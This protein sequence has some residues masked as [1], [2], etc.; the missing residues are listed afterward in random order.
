MAAK[1]TSGKR[2][3]YL[4][5]QPFRK[6]DRH[7]FFGR[8]EDIE[9]LHDFILLE[10]IVVLFGKSGYG[11]SSLLS[12]GVLPRLTDEAQPAAY[13]FRTVEARF[14]NYVEGSSFAPLETLR[15]ILE[16]EM[17][18]A[19]SAGSDLTNFQ[20]LSNLSPSNLSPSLWQLFKQ[21]QFSETPVGGRQSAVGGGNP[22]PVGSG[23]SAVGGGNPEPVGGGQS[24]EQPEIRNQES[25]IRNQESGI[26]NQE[27]E[28]R[29]QESAS[30]FLLVFDQFEEFFSYPAEQQEA[31]RRQLAELLY[32]DVPQQV[33]ENL[34]ALSPEARSRMATP[35]NVKAVFSI[36]SD[37][38]SHL[39]SMKD[40][41]PTILHKRY[42]LRP[43]TRSQAE[44]AIVMPARLGHDDAGSW[45]EQYATP[46]F[47]YERPALD[48]MLGS[49]ALESGGASAAGVEA[50]LLQILCDKVESLVREGKLPDLDGNGLPDVTAD[51]LPDMANL[52]EDYTHRKL[53]ELDPA[54]RPAARRLLEDGLL[55]E[56]ALSGEGRRTS[57]DG[58][59]LLAQFRQHGLSQALLDDLE[60]TYL[61]R[62]EPNT[63]GGFSYEI[64]HDRLVA[65]VQKM[66]KE[67]LVKEEKERLAKRQRQLVGIIALV[68]LV[69]GGAIALA[70]WA[71]GQKNEAVKAKVEAQQA[72]IQSYNSDIA[73][74]RQEIGVAERNLSTFEQY[75]A[76]PDVK[77]L[78][79]N[80]IDSLKELINTLDSKIKSLEK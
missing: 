8:D 9:N 79:S 6:G 4:G 14:G 69:A 80:R 72:L 65:P 59:A 1:P 33:R 78:E 20:N 5:V 28:I 55:A 73:R 24:V 54:Q 57:V 75:E 43:L 53:D 37:R 19:A 48:A 38:M 51:A 21:R 36:R 50:F 63:V 18:G 22:E 64:S 49:L 44:A 70:A 76:D 35:M 17:P 39:D 13:R 32:T 10:K 31:F 3:R 11:K 42:E 7:L 12:A 30:Q 77:L 61:L 67:R 15:R 34:D 46:P 23:Q 60:R 25:G 68:V 40:A 62:R 71:F 16:K 2:N 58:K 26:R 74:F 45:Q 41:L 66:K 29:N 56:D 52:L 47:E 27:S